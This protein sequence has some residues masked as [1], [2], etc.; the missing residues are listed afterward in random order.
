MSSETK[1]KELSKNRAYLVNFGGVEI[2]VLKLEGFRATQLGALL[3]PIGV[4]IEGK[5]AE[6][7]D[8]LALVKDK[9]QITMPYEV[10]VS[11]IARELSRAT[12]SSVNTIS[13][14]NNATVSSR[15]ISTAS[16]HVQ[17]SATVKDIKQS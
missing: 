16:L 3:S 10:W 14:A 6:A 15:E 17:G 9:N 5:Q 8:W 11:Q 1:V 12:G 2:L 7:N 13:V 4:N